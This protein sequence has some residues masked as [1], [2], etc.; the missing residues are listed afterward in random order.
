MLKK[1][2]LMQANEQAIKSAAALSDNQRSYTWLA[3][4]KY[5]KSDWKGFGLRH[6]CAP[7]FILSAV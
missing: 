5:D 1:A 3:Y 6:I 7:G 4:L 2:K